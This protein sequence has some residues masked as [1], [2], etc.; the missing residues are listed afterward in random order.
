MNYHL[1]ADVDAVNFAQAD[2]AELNCAPIELNISTPTT[3]D[4]RNNLS[5]EEYL[6]QANEDYEYCLYERDNIHF[7]RFSFVC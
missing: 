1:H 7:L 2:R 3:R 4:S 5:C 6:D